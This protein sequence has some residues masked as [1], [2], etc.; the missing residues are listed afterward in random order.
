MDIF[1]P[2][3]EQAIELAAQWHDSTYRKSRWRVPAFDPPDEAVLRVP[4]MAHVTA[5]ALI[6]QRAGWDDET[7]AAAFLHDVLEDLNRFGQTFRREQMREQVGEAITMLVEGVSEQKFDDQGRWRSW[8]DRKQDYVAQLRAGVAP[9]AAI[10]LA[11]KQH[12]LWSM[13][14]G[15]ASGLD[16]FTN[17]PNRRALSAGPEDQLWFHQAVVAASL[18][19]S[20]PRLEPMRVRLAR[21]IDRFRKMIGLP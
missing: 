21:E 17:G 14:E 7:V 9:A 12:N 19:H 10:S 11:D 1:S 18:N 6:V 20:D 15:L 3:I 13:N 8:H 5:V 4:A 16:I 2:L